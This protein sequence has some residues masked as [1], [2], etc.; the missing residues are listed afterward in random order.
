MFYLAGIPTREEDDA[1]KFI[2]ESTLGTVNKILKEEV[3]ELTN[4]LSE[5]IKELGE[6]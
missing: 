4:V 1:D 5:P 6:I 3:A 2:Q